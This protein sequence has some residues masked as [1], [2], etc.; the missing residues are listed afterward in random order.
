V[1]T[2][3][4]RIF[5]RGARVRRRRRGLALRLGGLKFRS[6]IVSRRGRC[7]SLDRERIVPFGRRYWTV[8]LITFVDKPAHY[9]S[10]LITLFPCTFV[11][12]HKSWEPDWL[13]VFCISQGA[14]SD[15]TVRRFLSVGDQCYEGKK[16]CVFVTRTG[17]HSQ[18]Q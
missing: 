15:N 14:Y 6:S 3:R 5:Y 18:F 16:V 17:C 10:N 7:A 1:R 9:L 13:N 4:I 11:Y 8:N 2:L 12:E